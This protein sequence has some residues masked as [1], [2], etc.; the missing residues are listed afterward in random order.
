M[1]ELNRRG[2][3]F[4]NELCNEVQGTTKRVP[5]VFYL[6][7]ERTLLQPLPKRHY[8][9]KKTVERKIS[10]D[11]YLSFGGNTYSVPVKYATRKVHVHLVYGYKIK[12]YDSKDNFIVDIEAFDGKKVIQSTKKDRCSHGCMCT[13]THRGT[14][15]YICPSDR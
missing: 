14:L 11:S 8:Y 9:H 1:E 15:K 10:A 3:E 6:L 4:V 13:A 5:N 2:K 7:E 12:F